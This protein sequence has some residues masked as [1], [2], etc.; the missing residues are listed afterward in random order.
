[1]LI[2][3]LHEGT[4]CMNSPYEWATEQ[5]G[6]VSTSGELCPAITCTVRGHELIS[7]WYAAQSGHYVH[8]KLQLPST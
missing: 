4:E 3:T 7:L 5:V 2:I 1:M 8:H 6:R